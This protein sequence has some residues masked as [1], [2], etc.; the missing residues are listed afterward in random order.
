MVSL[1][2]AAGHEPAF[3]TPAAK[4][5]AKTVFGKFHILCFHII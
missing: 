5:I 1:D 2:P 3:S 4:L